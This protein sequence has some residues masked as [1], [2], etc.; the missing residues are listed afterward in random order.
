VTTSGGAANRDGW[1]TGR[2]PWIDRGRSGRDVSGIRHALD[3]RRNPWPWKQKSGCRAGAPGVGSRNEAGP[4]LIARV[5][6]HGIALDLEQN[7]FTLKDPQRIAASL[8]NSAEASRRRRSDRF[9]SALPMLTFYLN[10]AGRNL[11]KGRRDI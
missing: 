7:F 8:K 4:T 3:S 1:C 6:R 9:R 2:E 5:T 11:P 10:R